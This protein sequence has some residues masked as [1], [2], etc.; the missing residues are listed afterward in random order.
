MMVDTLLELIFIVLAA[1][2]AAVAIGHFWGWYYAADTTQDE[3]HYVFTRDGWRLAVHRYRPEKGPKGLPVVLCHGLSANRYT[4]DLHGAP[5]LA[6]YL[7][8][9]GW[10]VWAPELRGSGM[11]QRPGLCYSNVP[12]SWDFEDH[13]QEDL[14]AIIACVLERT[15]AHSLHWVGHSMGGMLILAELAAR[16]NPPVASA[17]AIGS[18]VE[19]SNVK[20]SDIRLL[21][22]LKPLLNLMPVFLLGIVVRLGIPLVPQLALGFFHAPNVEP[23][24][25]RKIAALGLELLPSSKIWLNFARFVETEGFTS[26]DGGPYLANLSSSQAPILRLGGVMDGL[27]PPDSLIP[28]TEAEQPSGE[29]K[30]LILGKASGCVED[31]GHVDLMVG[32]RAENEVFPEIL[33]WLTDHDPSM[34]QMRGN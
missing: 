4:F 27:A 34:A 29:R 10:D 11:S 23:E 22:Q 7:R 1:G 2:M 19:F 12:Y 32:L 26:E 14:P 30:N 24:I 8:D 9:R 28:A 18:P 25:A 21:L 6:R 20:T 3:T 31:Y 13:W 33:Q 17:V 5:G 15:G 16:E